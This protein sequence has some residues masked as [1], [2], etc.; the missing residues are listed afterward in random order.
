MN[1]DGGA[2]PGGWCWIKQSKNVSG[3]YRISA[4]HYRIYFNTPMRHLSYTILSTTAAFN[5]SGSTQ[6]YISTQNYTEVVAISNGAAV[7]AFVYAA[8]FDN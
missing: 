1:F 7:D 5:I 8:V 3:V 4:G 2:C 6:S